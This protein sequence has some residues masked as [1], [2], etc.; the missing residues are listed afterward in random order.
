MPMAA[1]ESHDDRTQSFVALTSGA[2][3]SH[4][5][6]VEK[7]GAGGMGEVYLAEDTRLNRK[8]ALKFL[9]PH[10]CQDEDCRKRFTR[11]A[12]AAAGLDHPNIAA[13]HEVGEYQGRPYYAMQLV[14]GQSL[15]EVIAGEDLPI[16]QVL[17]IATQVCEGLQAAHDKGVIHRDIK[18]SNILLDTH[19]RVRIVDFGLASMRGA[20]HLTKTG[21]TLG[22]V[23]YM[24]P[25]QAEG[26]EID[27]QT[28]IWSLGVVLYEMLTGRL[29]FKRDHD[30]ATIHAILNEEPE[31]PGSFR[32]GIPQ[33]IEQII[34]KALEKDSARRYQNT[35]LFLQDLKT[36]SSTSVTLQ[37]Q[38]VSI[39]VL[40]F[41]DLSPG[42]DQEYFSDGLTEEIITDLSHIR[43]LLVI[44]RSS[45]MT[46]KGTKKKIREIAREVDVRYVLEGSVRKA[47][48]N[49]RITA[50]L[51]DAANDSHL[52]AEKYKGTL[53]DI[54][55]IQE[56]VSRSIMDSLKIKLSTEENKRIAEHPIENVQ[57]YEC[58]LIAMADIIKHT[59]K[60]IEDAIRNLQHAMDII[61]DNALLFSGMAMAYWG[62]VNIGVRQ[63]DYLA[64]AR[65]SVKRALELNPEHPSVLALAGWIPVRPRSRR[66]EVLH[67]KRVLR[68]SPD[69]IVA[70][71]GM[72]VVCEFTGKIPAAVPY[73]ERLVR[74]DP[75]GFTTPWFQGAQHFYGGQYDDALQAWRR[76]YELH[77]DNPFSQFYY[78]L[79]LCY[80]N[81]L[82][83]AFPIIDHSAKANP[84]HTLTKLGFVLKY[85]LQG[86]KESTF[87]EMTQDF[88][89]TCQRD[90]SYSHHLAGIFA[91]LD[92]K[93]EAF[94][95]LENAVSRGFINYPLLSQKDPWLENLRGEER[96]KKLMERVRREW[97]EFEV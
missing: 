95:W 17:E 43:D 97:E 61:G 70:L 66:E 9:P 2:T 47:G 93:E 53:D 10:L 68:I 55:D 52:W 41:D 57:A 83:E 33:H 39:V 45:A 81:Q 60:D 80:R 48:N 29:P 51:I 54:F 50:Q 46:F 38:E 1:D 16:E 92:E 22:T 90:S 89:K 56:K 19:G 94:N 77:P 72:L 24:S 6:I 96:F 12:Q 26:K 58:Y 71:I 86:D 79:T 78:A 36:C 69:E 8:V 91:L 32:S 15:R 5:R 74:I 82:S 64:K 63:E 13:I 42:K 34:Q 40:P 14:E 3:V 49:L 88:R 21:S 76:C 87:K 27:H 67:L 37:R 84:N 65:E 59:E 62:L 18:P 4:Y 28:D 85:G 44:S 35:Q 75:L 31:P 7:I 30:Q 20:E 73:F 11:E 25:E 23:G